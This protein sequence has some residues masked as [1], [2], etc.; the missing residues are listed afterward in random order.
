MDQDARRSMS[1]HE[2]D[3]VNATGSVYM[4]N[5]SPE[6]EAEQENSPFH[7]L[8]AKVIEQILYAVDANTFASLAVLNRQWRRV[9]DTPELYAHHISRCPLF[10]VTRDVIAGPLRPEDFPQLK[11]K[12][13]REIRRNAFEVFLRPAKTLVT[14]IS[15]SAGSSTALPQ[16]EALKFSFSPNGQTLLCLSSS[17]IFVLDVASPRITVMHELKTLRVPLAATVL[18]DGKLLAVVSSRLQ[19]NIYHLSREEAQHVQA[20]TLNDVPRALTLSPTGSILAV[21]YD[22]SI[23][24]YALGENTFA[25]PRRAVRCIGVDTLSFTS[26][27]TM[28]LGS[29]MDPSRAGVV[30]ITAPFPTDSAVDVGSSNA[31]SQIWTTQILFPEIISGYSHVSLFPGHMG[32]E[33]NWIVGF[34]NE[35]KAFRAVRVN[36]AKTGATFFIGPAPNDGLEEP[37]PALSPAVDSNGELVALAFQG[38]G[39]WLYGL[40]DH[41]DLTP[42]EANGTVGVN[43]TRI[44]MQASPDPPSEDSDGT[45]I[46]RLQRTINQP[47]L[48]IRG[49]KVA[50]IPGLTAARWIGQRPS[51]ESNNSPGRHRLVAVAPGG[52]TFSSLGVEAIPV[53]GG[54]I[55]I[56][57]FERSPKDGE[58]VELTLELGEAEPKVLREQN[59]NLEQ[60]V[61]LERRRTQLRRGVVGSPRNNVWDRPGSLSRQSFPVARSSSQK[62]AHSSQ[63]GSRSQ[64]S[65]PTQA[66]FGDLTL[67]LDGPYS[68]TAPRSRDT[69]HR[70]A[71]AAAASRRNQPQYRA[72]EN[73]SQIEGQIP[74]ESDADNWVPPPPPYTRDAD[75][76]LPEHIRRLLLPTMTEPPGTVM[77]VPV[78]IRRAQTT[79]YDT[80]GEESERHRSRLERIGS[81]RRSRLLRRRSTREPNAGDL[82][83]ARRMSLWRGRESIFT[84]SQPGTPRV[85]E[86][87]QPLNS[88][89]PPVP[90]VP[91]IPPVPP[92]PSVP[93]VPPVPQVP[94]VPPVPAVQHPETYPQAPSIPA[95]TLTTQSTGPRRRQSQFR[96]SLF[97]AGFLHRTRSQAGWQDHPTAQEPQHVS[98]VDGNQSRASRYMFSQSTPH[99]PLGESMVHRMDTIHSSEYRPGGAGGVYRSRSRSEDIQSPIRLTQENIQSLQQADAGQGMFA[100]PNPEELR[101]WQ[102]PDAAE[103][104]EWRARIEQW[105]LHTI[106][107]TQKKNRSKCSVM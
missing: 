11:R 18:D 35:I 57:D 78:E 31:Q 105:N 77:D 67:F 98:R 71:T 27:G 49:H 55:F 82:A 101:N 85:G 92:V 10:S 34:D 81:I 102:H 59:A 100:R 69:L 36:D 64:A 87:I 60:E 45:N 14:L 104:D 30:T 68:N 25:T 65:S 15:T 97:S 80:G 38:R 33:D 56:F 62:L 47:S 72:Q 22:G 51:A 3:V 26:D 5:G 44:F 89:V 50:D 83:P 88:P 66:E 106:N 90:P 42:L 86:L 16:G 74:H 58:T 1:G 20:L 95:D 61:E 28:L 93:P 29:S 76:P 17:R 12:F 4:E 21:A 23:E 24:V 41:I 39:V 91:S 37:Q 46:R 107:E 40:P 43:G 6:R 19:V 2:D 79:V 53:D 13:A 8:P 7:R 63:R 32:D 70:A 73:S 54:R 96:S 84:T 94:P 103:S 52:V 75:E 48:L 99:L 9:S